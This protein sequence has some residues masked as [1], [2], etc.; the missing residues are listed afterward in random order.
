MNPVAPVYRPWVGTVA[1]V[2]VPGAGL[3]LSGRRRAGVVWFGGL[4]GLTLVSAALAPLSALPGVWHVWGLD[5]ANLVL[6]VVM[7]AQS[8]RPIPRQSRARWLGLALL[9]AAV[10]F[11]TWWL[12]ERLALVMEMPSHTMAPA[13]QGAPLGPV[14]PTGSDGRLLIQRT[15]YWFAEPARGHIVVFRPDGLTNTVSGY[16]HLRRVVG[17]PG[18]VIHFREGRLEVNGQVV[19][20]PPVF[21]RLRYTSTLALSNLLGVAESFRVRE[22]CYFVAG[23][24]AAISLDSRHYGPVPR[25]NLIGRA[26]QIIWPLSRVGNLE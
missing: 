10:F 11:G 26:T 19:A 5:L 22:G 24:H 9:G 17:L 4:M 7:L 12:T 23:D 18:E 21:N 6:C 2:L 13:V 14:G 15:V 16:P 3:F 20:H 25:S 8:W 1:S